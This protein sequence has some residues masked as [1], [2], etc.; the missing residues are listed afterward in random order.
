MALW[1]PFTDVFEDPA[2]EKARAETFR[3]TESSW[4]VTL[5][6]PPPALMRFERAFR[7]DWKPRVET[8]P[9]E[10]TEYSVEVTL[11]APAM[12]AEIL[13]DRALTTD[14]KPFVE[15][16]PTDR[17]DRLVKTRVESTDTC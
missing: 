4:L 17:A 9:T 13:L 2:A 11:V 5:P 16:P 7:T 14:C 10:R 1:S 12:T 3:A 6:V 8:L 15:I